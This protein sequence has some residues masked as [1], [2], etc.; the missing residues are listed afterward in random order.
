M[1]TY[2]VTIQMKPL[3][4][5]FHPVL[6]VFQHFYNMEFRNFVTFCGQF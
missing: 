2:D 4:Q 6:F 3:Q 5:Y 1:K